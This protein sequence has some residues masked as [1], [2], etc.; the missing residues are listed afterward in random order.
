MKL[1]PAHS[2]HAHHLDI[3]PIWVIS[4]INYAVKFP[5]TEVFVGIGVYVIL[6]GIIV[7]QFIF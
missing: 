1:F 2:G 4:L 6:I 7:I 3:N 5:S